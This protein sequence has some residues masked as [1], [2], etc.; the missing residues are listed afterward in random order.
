MVVWATSRHSLGSIP[1][2]KKFRSGRFRDLLF[3]CRCAWPP[4]SRCES[5][6]QRP[7][8]FHQYRL[9]TAYS[10][11]FGNT[12]SSRVWT[13]HAEN[14]HDL[15][16]AGCSNES[17]NADGGRVEPH[18]READHCQYNFARRLC[19]NAWI[20][21]NGRRRSQSDPVTGLRQYS[22]LHEWWQ[23]YH[24]NG[25]KAGPRPCKPRCKIRAYLG[26]F[27]ESISGGWGATL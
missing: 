2:R 16:C 1:E 6:V 15:Y 8:I 27:A 12:S 11:K 26:D 14:L 13:G 20:P 4:I 25:W 9:S 7:D 3:R 17:Q 21:C 19:R 23:C 10:I 22:R 18:C 5:A 24:P